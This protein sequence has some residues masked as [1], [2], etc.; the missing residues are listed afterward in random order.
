MADIRFAR[1]LKAWTE[2]QMRLLP[3]LRES[4]K[5]RAAP[6][7]ASSRAV[8]FIE[9]RSHPAIEFVLQTTR[10]FLPEWPIL[11][12]HGTTNEDYV[13]QIARNMQLDS[14]VIEFVNC[15]LDNLPNR[16]YNTMLTSP[17]FW[18]AISSSRFRP[19][20][21]LTMQTDATLMC[22]AA[23]KLEALITEGVKFCGA[24]WAYTCQVCGGPLDARCGHMIDQAVV[25]ELAPNMVGNGGFSLRSVSTFADAL[26]KF[27]LEPA[28]DP[29]A[30]VHWPGNPE[31]ETLRG[32]SN[33]DVFFVKALCKM[34]LSGSIASRRT[35]LAFAIEQVPPEEW[36]PSGTLALG[37]H[38]PW[39]YLNDKLVD[40]IFKRIEV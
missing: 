37:V 3:R 12:V 1:G 38:K 23:E 4:Q 7:L 40:A 5:T 20:Y 26:G 16:A 6:I 25:A 28:R 34:G 15:K 10:R 29:A 30:D 39:G 2:L 8:L 32:T 35:A 24:P 19:D 33:E 11:F 9:P 17:A 31:A 27:K 13:R 14:T 18:K 36:K 22:D 21:V